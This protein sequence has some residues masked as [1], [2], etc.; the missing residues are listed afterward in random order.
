MSCWR[1]VCKRCA[2]SHGTKLEVATRRKWNLLEG[3]EKGWHGLAWYSCELWD[4]FHNKLPVDFRHLCC[5]TTTSWERRWGPVPSAPSSWA[6]ARRRRI[7]PLQLVKDFDS[8]HIILGVHAR[9]KTFIPH[10]WQPGNI[11]YILLIFAEEQVSAPPPMHGKM[12]FT[13][14]RSEA[15]KTHWDRTIGS[16]VK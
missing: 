1:G 5:R 9:R 8:R 7:P 13:K 2:S 4:N 15:P 11:A 16:Y 3:V 14:Y 6:T 10:T 12:K